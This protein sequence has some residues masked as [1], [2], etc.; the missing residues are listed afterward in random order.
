MDEGQAGGTRKLDPIA[1]ARLQDT[2][3]EVHNPPP[4]LR[5]IGVAR[6]DK[7]MVGDVADRK[8]DVEGVAQ[9]LP[10]CQIRESNRCCLSGVPVRRTVT[11]FWTWT[12]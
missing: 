7:L 2:S 3:D 12:Q 6:R 5:I 10:A 8:R 11:A 4:R 1:L 9:E